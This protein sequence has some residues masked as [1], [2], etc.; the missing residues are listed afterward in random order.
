MPT[1]RTYIRRPHRHR[2]SHAQ[3]LD[4]W[5]GS[6]PQ[7]CPHPFDSDE[8]RREAWA[9]HRNW[10]MAL[11]ANHG[12]R[13]MAWWQYEAPIFYPGYDREQSTL[14]EAGLL[15]EAEKAELLAEWRRYFEKALEPGFSHCI[16]HAR[17]QDT[18]ATWL[19]GAAAKRAHYAWADIPRALV[20]AW[21]GE[22]RRRA[23]TIRK[24][25]ETNEPPKEGTPERAQEDAARGP[26]G[27]KRD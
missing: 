22:Y 12:R 8:E 10:L 16:G 1:S 20:K 18:F 9:K 25:A 7:Y 27:Q 2:L 14:Y 23:K 13:P 15:A 26:E 4:L 19:H 11:F 24:L 5:L 17:P 6:G 21:T 3:E